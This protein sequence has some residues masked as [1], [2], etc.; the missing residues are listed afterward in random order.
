MKSLRRQ[1]KLPAATNPAAQLAASAGAPPPASAA[2]GKRRL[3][4]S[5]AAGVL[6]PLAGRHDSINA[7]RGG[8]GGPGDVSAAGPATT[9]KGGEA[10][11]ADPDADRRR[12]SIME[13]IAAGLPSG[14]EVVS[15]PL[16][17]D[18]WERRQAE[19]C[20]DL[21]EDIDEELRSRLSAEVREGA[22]E[23][24]PHRATPSDR[25]LT[26]PHRTCCQ[27]HERLGKHVS[28]F[29]R[30]VEDLSGSPLAAMIRKL[31]MVITQARRN[32]TGAP[33]PARRSRA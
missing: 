32:Y 30:G 28:L 2:A 22:V 31:D 13:L 33:L 25:L 26:P 17:L 27:V 10:A 21:A 19:A 18:A 14:G 3:S 15:F 16:T 4:A 7:L 12:G 1:L 24:A 23:G 29:L 8:A 20:V 5:E 11:A 6:A 9:G